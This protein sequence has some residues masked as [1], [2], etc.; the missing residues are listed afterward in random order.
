MSD[1]LAH[2]RQLLAQSLEDAGLPLPQPP[3]ALAALVPYGVAL[4]YDALDEDEPRLDRGALRRQVDQW[5]A[6][7]NRFAEGGGT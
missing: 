6:W 5:L 3:E 7:A 4:R 2:A 1:A